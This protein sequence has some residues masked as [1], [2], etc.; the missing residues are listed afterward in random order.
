L[1]RHDPGHILL[2]AAWTDTAAGLLDLRRLGAF[3]ARITGRIRHVG[4]ARVS[5]LAVPLLLEIGRESVHGQAA[6][7]IMRDALAD[8]LRD[9]TAESGAAPTLN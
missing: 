1:R 3:L 8:M 5:P 2:E 7:G 9:I 6:D 4:L